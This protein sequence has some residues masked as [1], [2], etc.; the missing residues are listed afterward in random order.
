MSTATALQVDLAVTP[1]SRRG[2]Y[3]AVSHTVDQ[4]EPGFYLRTVRGDARHREILRLLL[5]DAPD[6]RSLTTAG[7]LT[8]SRGATRVDVLLD[9]PDRA[10]LQVEG[11]SLTLDFR[12]TSQYDSVLQ[13]NEN[14]WRFVDSGANRNYRVRVLDGAARLDA[15]WDGTRNTEARLRT[16]AQEDAATIVIDEYGSAAP[17]RPLNPPTAVALAAQADFDAWCRTHGG[18]AC[19]D[20]AVSDSVRLAAYVTWAALAPAGGLLR[21][22]SMLMSKNWMTNIWSWDHCFNAMALWRDPHAA[23][24]QLFAVFDH[25][26]EHGCLPDYVNDA[27]IQRNFVKPPIH[28]WAVAHL[29]DRDGLDETTIAALYEPLRRWTEWWFEHRVYGDDG[30]PSYNHG[31]D[32]GWDNATTFG[33]GVPV[34]SPDLLAF[35]AL[36]MLTLARIA[37]RTGRGEE[38]AA[39]RRRA[40]RTVRTMCERFWSDGRFVARHTLTGRV[41]AADSLLTLMPLVLGDL[42]PHDVRDTTVRRLLDGGYLTPYGPA[43]EPV[44]SPFYEAD[45]Y[46]R[47]PIWAPSTMLLVDGLRRSG[48]TDVA[49][50][51]AARFTATCAA[52]GMAENFDALTGAGLRDRSMTWTASVYLTLVS[53]RAG[54]PTPTTDRAREHAS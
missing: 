50:D 26:D 44:D 10:V 43:T 37:A 47:G 25:Q 31:N 24:D 28:G 34:Q 46:W 27:G 16:T 15:R 9:G 30:I 18:A 7:R 2:S 14:T 12:A 11:G 23:A 54:R 29:M 40:E 32:S 38:S 1:F 13:E 5:D 8:L 41:V 20:P 53:E 19:D 4:H 6:A 42:L 22:E 17:T 35:L 33:A 51:I 21:R 48:R 36:Q 45:G 52:A 3:F 49:D 39:W